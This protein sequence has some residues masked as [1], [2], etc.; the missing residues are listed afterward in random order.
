[1][2]TK[3][4]CSRR[5]YL[6]LSLGFGLGFTAVLLLGLHFSATATVQPPGPRLSKTI[7]FDPGIGLEPHAVAID[8]DT[9]LVYVANEG[10]N[11]VSVISGT[12]VITNLIVGGGPS[13]IDANP[14][15]GY[16]YVANTQSPDLVVIQATDI[17]SRLVVS[18]LEL[19]DFPRALASNPGNGFTYLAVEG[20]N[21]RV[22]VIDGTD[23]ITRLNVA[24]SPMDLAVDPVHG[25]TYV[26]TRAGIINIIRGTGLAGEIDLGAGLNAID[27]N[28]RTGLLYAINNITRQ[29][30]VIRA[31]QVVAS[32]PLDSYAV[33]VGVNPESGYVYVT[34]PNKSSAMVISGTQVITSLLVG[35]YSVQVSI[36]PDGDSVYIT[37]PG[38]YSDRAG[39]LTLIHGL[40]VV[41]D[42]ATGLSPSDVAIHP[43][44]D[45]AYV[46]NS[47]SNDVSVIAG[48][49]EV[50]IIP[51]GT[52]PD[53]LLFNPEN[54][55]IYL[56]D[57]VGNNVVVLQGD[58]V[59]AR[60]HVG[61]SP[62]SL[63]FDPGNGWVYVANYLSSS[64]SI[65]SDAQVITTVVGIPNP[66]GIAVHP[67]TRIAYVCSEGKI[68]LLQGIQ[69]IGQVAGSYCRPEKLKINPRTGLVYSLRYDQTVDVIDGSQVVA[70]PELK[71]EGEDLAFDLSTGLVYITGERWVTVLDRD[72]VIAAI[73]LGLH[74]YDLY[75]YIGFSPASNL[76]YV[77][78][79]N[80]DQ[81]AAL[82][83]TQLVEYVKTCHGPNTIV[84]DPLSSRVYVTCQYSP[85]FVTLSGTEV[86]NRI[87]LAS[88]PPLEPWQLYPTYPR[89]LAVDSQSGAVYMSNYYHHS[90]S[91]LE[92]LPD[93]NLEPVNQFWRGMIGAR[94]I[95]GV[96]LVSQLGFNQPVSLSITGWPE[97]ISWTIVPNPVTPSE[98][99][100]MVVVDYTVS[101]NAPVGNSLLIISGVS[102][103]TVHRA[104]VPL[105]VYKDLSFFPFV[106]LRD[107]YAPTPTPTVT[108]WQTATPSPTTTPWPPSR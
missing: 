15:S 44:N 40:Q 105:L 65:L 55:Y 71:S 37:H 27:F 98:T 85:D 83:G 23:I 19:K 2:N 7:A 64:I 103:S 61:R 1:M 76:F 25:E 68:T 84:P 42:V 16:I 102:G 41:G 66:V 13:F 54:G 82:R 97:G 51:P 18:S 95:Q 24:Y 79:V 69:V 26:A 108:P 31:A 101:A 21:S 14:V 77:G 90:L 59:I 6:C 72:R 60:L 29:V 34:M 35:T 47:G 89:P 8:P 53:Q 104:Q 63:A 36:S 20:W 56:A 99:I 43:I 33:D 67:V 96:E 17:I 28:P 38:Y 91:I 48:I 57:P 88:F 78:N 52:F 3:Y 49:N 58:Q 39:S 74:Q 5:F 30:V 94:H 70:T 22:V 4:T 87:E 32:L 9:G 106:G 107:P 93:F 50:A 62:L 46:T 80:D 73:P 45:Y 10:S 11:E 12:R 92:L 86:I 75:S 81:T 100:G